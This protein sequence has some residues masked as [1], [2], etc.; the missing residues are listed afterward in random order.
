MKEDRKKI[1]AFEL[2]CWRRACWV[3][4][5]DKVSNKSILTWVAPYNKLSLDARILKKKES[6]FGHVMRRNGMEKDI[7]LGK[8]GGRRRRG[9]Q[10]MRWMEGI[11]TETGNGLK[12]LRE[13]V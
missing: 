7:M 5:T 8:V 3:K 13:L 9:R 6:Y 12:E 2:W 11:L 1:D 4:W 10:M